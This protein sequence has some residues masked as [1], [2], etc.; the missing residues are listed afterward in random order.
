VKEDFTGGGSAPSQAQHFLDVPG[1]VEPS[2]ARARRLRLHT[3]HELIAVMRSDSPVCHAEGLA[4]HTQIYIRNG[5]RPI[6]ATLFQVD[7]E[8]LAGDEIGLSEA[9]WQALGVDEG[10][11]VQVGHAPPLESI[12]CVRQRIYGHRLNA[13]ALRS[14]VE[15]VVAGRYSDVHLAAFLTATAALPFDEDETYSLTKAMVDA[16]DRLRWPSE[17]VVDKH[18]VGGLP[19]N[20]TTPIIV[21]IAAAC[22][23]TMPK[24]SSRAITSPAGTADTMETLTRVDLDLEAMQRVVASEG[25]C[26]AWGGAVRLSPAD[27]IFIGV[28]RALD[29][30]TEGQLIASVLS[31]KI[32]AGATHVVL[33]IPVGPTAK[34]RSAD[35]AERLAATLT[36]VAGRFGLITRCVQTDGTQP[37]GRA[38]GP[39]L[40]ARDVL[41]VLTGDPD[42]PMDLR[43]RVCILA[44]VILEIGEV[45]LAGTGRAL[46]EQTLADGSAWKKFQRICDA[47][48]GMRTPPTARLTHPIVAS[49]SGRVTHIDNRRIARLAKL[50]GAPDVPAAGMRLHVSLGDDII[51]GQ[52]LLTLHAQSRGEM[53]YALTYA[54]SNSDMIVIVP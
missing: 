43:D 41:A 20:R 51:A 36:T 1:Q 25:G 46:A 23:L 8:F 21:A 15:D 26:L 5:G 19:G 14:I 7:G 45:A 40:E 52:P 29:I 11:I 30:D 3:H 12:T 13:A 10:T 18:S 47:Q 31:K 38:I 39:A 37:V 44:G 16:G 28:E 4:A 17:I 54:A 33:D 53:A 50:A 49:H 2:F 6:A 42:A 9:A 34:V 48:G 24:T 32:A 27:D 22:G 35:A